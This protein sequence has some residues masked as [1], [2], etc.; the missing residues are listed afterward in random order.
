MLGST[1]ASVMNLV[2]NEIRASL[3]A[4]T[5]DDAAIKQAVETKQ[6]WLA[7][8]FDWAELDDEWDATATG[9]YT[10][11]PTTDVAAASRSINF[12]RAVQLSH[13]WNSIWNSIQNGITLEQYNAF[14]SD[15]GD[16]QDPVLAWRFKP[17]DRTYFEVWPIPTASAALRFT[18]QRKLLTLRTA[19]VL[20]TAKTLDLDDM[21]VAFAVAA[22][23]LS[24]KPEQASKAELFQ[25]RFTA[26]RSANK[27]SD[28]RFFIGGDQRSSR[29]TLRRSKLVMVT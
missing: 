9:R 26:V 10:A 8:M 17:G 11:V 15:A 19:S 3:S 21:L 28:E 12:D 7:S 4:G 18:G 24:G 2:K 27:T 20:D 5:A 1:L 16:R 6:E 29:Q 13:K 22:D 25:M 14:D 23:F